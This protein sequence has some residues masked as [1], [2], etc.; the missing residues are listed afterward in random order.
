M[1]TKLGTEEIFDCTYID[2]LLYVLKIIIDTIEK[3][4][5]NRVKNWYVEL[6][7]FAMPVLKTSPIPSRCHSGKI[8]VHRHPTGR[9]R[10]RGMSRS[11]TVEIGATKIFRALL[12]DIINNLSGVC[13]IDHPLLAVH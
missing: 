12:I 7:L 11:F 1:R 6:N 8:N 2:S 9:R 3:K 13:L 4:L 10:S 5:S